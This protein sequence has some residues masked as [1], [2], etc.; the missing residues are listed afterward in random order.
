MAL[1]KENSVGVSKIILINIEDIK[2][3]N[4]IIIKRKYGK[5]KRIVLEYKF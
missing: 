1:C 2:S 3:F 5:R 4:P